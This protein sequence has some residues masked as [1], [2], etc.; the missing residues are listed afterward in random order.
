MKKLLTRVLTLIMMVS[1]IMALAIADETDS[2]TVY[3]TISDGT[4]KLVVSQEAVIVTDSDADGALTINDALYAAHEAKYEG[5]AA[6]GYL[7]YS[8][9]F[10]V[11]L[12]KLWG[13]NNGG[14]YGYYVNNAS[15]WGLTDTVEA[16]DY[17][18]AYVFTDLT[19]WSD[20]YSFFDKNNVSAK[21][22]EAVE[23]TLSMAG[24]DASWNP[25]TLPVEG[26]TITIDGV[27]SEYKTDAEGKVSITLEEGSHVISAVSETVTL[28]PPVCV[29]EVTAKNAGDDNSDSSNETAPEGNDPQPETGDVAGLALLTV[30]TVTAFAGV[31]A[32]ALRKKGGYEK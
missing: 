21:S 4:G 10:G 31:V 25:V 9:E 18:N 19:T 1:T 28:V 20:T 12:S 15:A 6:E 8:S 13:E 22:G 26:A 27:V 14:A 7:A 23:L 11:S 24:Y 2:V 29:V 3:V 30:C 17:V 16:N 32:S 5:G